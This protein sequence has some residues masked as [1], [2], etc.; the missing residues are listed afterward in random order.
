MNFEGDEQQKELAK[1]EMYQ[2]SWKIKCA[3]KNQPDLINKAGKKLDPNTT[4]LEEAVVNVH[5][6]PWVYTK[7]SNGIKYILNGI[8]VITEGTSFGALSSDEAFDICPDEED[9]DSIFDTS[10]EVP[11]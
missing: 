8:Q 5:I 1:L 2:K 6:S 11:F 3:S 9:K 10:A 4:G 7:P